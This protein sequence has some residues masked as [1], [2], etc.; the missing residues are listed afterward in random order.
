MCRLPTRNRHF[1]GL[2]K[3]SDSYVTTK[4]IT[5]GLS[6]CPDEVFVSVAMVSTHTHFYSDVLSTLAI[7][8]FNDDSRD[9]DPAFQHGRIDDGDPV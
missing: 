6:D 2:L 1:N 4:V 9:V 5:A 7:G 3:I 8:F